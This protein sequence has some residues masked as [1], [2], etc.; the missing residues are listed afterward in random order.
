MQKICPICRQTGNVDDD[1][2]NCVREGRM[3][4]I[5]VIWADEKLVGIAQRLMDKG[6]RVNSC[7]LHG[8]GIYSKPAIRIYFDEHYDIESLFHDMPPGW[9]TETFL[10]NGGSRK[11]TVLA[12]DC[13]CDDEDLEYELVLTISNLETWLDSIDSEA[14]KAVLILAGYSTEPVIH[15]R[16]E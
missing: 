12:E 13:E 15:T 5:D 16:E 10:G 8:N 2:C 14:A 1:Y 9:Y 6:F 11:F 3:S 7:I 4:A